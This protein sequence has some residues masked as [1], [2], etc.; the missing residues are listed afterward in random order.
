M[1]LNSSTAK[2]EIFRT[3]NLNDKILKVKIGASPI[4]ES[5]LMEG[6][7]VPSNALVLPSV[8]SD[9]LICGVLRG[10]SGTEK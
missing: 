10:D 9:G 6:Q 2:V 3:Q 8:R 4:Q 7:G 1:D 5:K